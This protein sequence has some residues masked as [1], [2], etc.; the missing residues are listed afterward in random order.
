MSRKRLQFQALLRLFA[1]CIGENTQE[2][3]EPAQRHV[4]LEIVPV[5]V[6]PALRVDR[7][8]L[9]VCFCCL[10][11]FLSLA[12]L[13]ACRKIAVLFICGTKGNVHVG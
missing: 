6:H 1:F 3:R 8:L 7:L 11:L 5:L 9:T 4:L 12:Q 2:K 13:C 10:T